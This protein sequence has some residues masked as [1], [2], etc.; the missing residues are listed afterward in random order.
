MASVAETGD[1][2]RLGYSEIAS[3]VV[4]EI[5]NIT[6]D[7]RRAIFALI[8]QEGIEVQRKLITVNNQKLHDVLTNGGN[9]IDEDTR[10]SLVFRLEDST[11]P[12]ERLRREE[13]ELNISFIR[14]SSLNEARLAIVNSL[15]KTLKMHNIARG[16]DT[17]SVYSDLYLV[18]CYWN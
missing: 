17:D 5:G 1:R 6:P 14:D 9:L 16:N 15:E 13:F 11:V 12:L 10:K 3:E 2:N 18:M 4:A 7:H 8:L